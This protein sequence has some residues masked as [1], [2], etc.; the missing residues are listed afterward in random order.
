MRTIKFRGR[1]AGGWV[2]GD[3]E[4]F[5]GCAM[6]HTERGSSTGVDMASVG[7]YISVQYVRDEQTGALLIVLKVWSKKHKRWRYE[8]WHA[9]EYDMEFREEEI[10]KQLEE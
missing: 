1:N 3:L 6:I 10:Y 2:Y 4:Q 5:G 7:Q 8:V 9:W